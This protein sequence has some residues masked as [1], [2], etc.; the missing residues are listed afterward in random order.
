MG[1]NRLKIRSGG[2]LLEGLNGEDYLYFAHSFAAQANNGETT[3]TC[4]YGGEFAA[5][6]S[7]DKLCA[8]QFHPEKSGNAGAKLLRN[9]LRM[10]A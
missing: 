1:W 4:D 9:F 3:A 5:V 7:V 8:V 2:A 6:L 10:A